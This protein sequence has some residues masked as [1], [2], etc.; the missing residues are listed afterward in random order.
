MTIT[1]NQLYEAAFRYKKT[2]IWRKLWDNHVF[3]VKLPS[4]EIG[5][6]SIMGRSGEYNALGLYIGEE[7]FRSYRFVANRD[8]SACSIFMEHEI[9][10]R[11]KCLQ[12]AFESRGDLLPD[13][14]EE[15]RAYARENGIK[16]TG[17]NAYPNLQKIEPYCFPWKV[18]TEEDMEA[19]YT[20]LCASNLLAR[21][22]RKSSVTSIG[23]HRIGPKTKDVPLFEIND[24]ELISAGRVPIPGDVKEEYHYV[25]I[26]N[27]IA[28][29]AVK[30]LPKRG[31]FEAEFI[32]LPQPVQDDPE[33][34]PYFP[35]LLF[36]VK[37]EDFY[38]L[39]TTVIR[40]G[41]KNPEEVLKNFANTLRK[42][43]VRPEEIRCGDERTYALLKDFCE[44][45]EIGI[46]I[47]DGVLYALDDAEASMMEL[48]LGM[49]P[50]LDEDEMVDVIDR[51][52]DLVLDSSEEEIRM[53]PTEIL[54]DLRMMIDS[55][56][57]NEETEEELRRKLQF[58]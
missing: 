3:A 40:H 34:P 45:T 7:G 52:I 24:N 41:E 47:Y 42:E 50:D 27:D 4:G 51:F 44:K 17:K 11:Q 39:P 46:G 55:G 8:Y 14:Q 19:L 26:E 25:K 54:E 1:K 58:C 32:C 16:L 28:L 13:V 2:G 43:N 49:N 53:M 21:K 12:A 57:L 29:A 37:G 10:V 30:K 48:S 22:I 23:I 5:Y 33:E 35:F 36:I 15:V 9:M 6:V 56:M 20:A 18:E 31:V 38:A